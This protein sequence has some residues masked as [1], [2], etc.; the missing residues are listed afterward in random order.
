MSIKVKE[1]KN[2]ALINV[3]VNKNFYMMVKNSLYYLF[4]LEKDLKVKEES[5][6]KI[7]EASYDQLND[8]EK[9]FYCLSL[10]IAEIERVAAIEKLYEEK[11]ILQPGDEGYEEPK[12][13]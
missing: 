8:Y 3:A 4:M 9:T 6:K 7:K 5:L 11:E 2:D 1:L 12:L 13:D 10:L